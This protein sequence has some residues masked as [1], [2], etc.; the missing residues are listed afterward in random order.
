[1]SNYDKLS[2]PY[3][4]ND[5]DNVPKGVTL[6]LRKLIGEH[7]DNAFNSTCRYNIIKGSRNSKKSVDIIGYRAIY[8]ILEDKLNNV[9]VVRENEYTNRQSTFANIINCINTMGIGQYFKI[10]KNPL[11]ITYKPTGQMIFFRGMNN[12]TTITSITVQIGILNRVY[13]EEAYEIPTYE[14]FRKLDGSIRGVV[15]TPKNYFKITMVLNGWNIEHWIHD[16]FFVDK[17]THEE[18]LA[19]DINELE[20]KGIQEYCDPEYIGDYGKGLYLATTNYLVNEF[21]DP[22]YDLSAKEMKK[23]SIDIYLVEYLG[24]WGNPRNITYPEFS[25]DLVKPPSQLAE[26]KYIDYAIGVDTGLSNG[27]GNVI[28]KKDKELVRSATTM[29]LKGITNGYKE[30]VALQE[31][32]WTN[33]GKAVP[34]TEPQLYEEMIDEIVKWKET[35]RSDNILMKGI[36]YVF[37]DC[38]DIGF[39]QGLELVARKR[40]IIN[41]KFIGSTKHKIQTRIDYTRLQMAWGEY[42]VSTMCPNLIREIKACRT[43]DNG[44]PRLDTNDHAIN[45]DEYGFAPFMSRMSRW[46]TFKEH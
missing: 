41:I 42:L 36:C 40:N 20:S 22:F 25:Q 45:A 33:E 5:D 13:I 11:E 46:K 44:A 24:C 18:R 1:M 31:Y 43:G 6:S 30:Q 29:V 38:A 12:P 8:D 35:Y 15:P 32:Y 27:E 17:E 23:R 19:D 34:K 16:V 28:R 21:R 37:V 7:Y 39:R 2:R 26:Y 3:A 9:L 10:N 4:D 14:D